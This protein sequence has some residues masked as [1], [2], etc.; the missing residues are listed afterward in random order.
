M[1]R[2]A[3]KRG[4][5]VEGSRQTLSVAKNPTLIPEPPTGPND[6]ID[7]QF[8][9]DFVITSR[10]NSPMV[11]DTPSASIPPPVIRPA[12]QQD[13]EP[14][15][16]FIRP[17]VSAGRLLERTMAELDL[18]IE[19]GFV[20]EADGRIVGFAALEV[21][22]RKLAEIRSLA[23]AEPYR[24]LGVGKQLIAA[25]LSLARERNIMEIMAITSNETFF[26]S[27]GFDFTL[28]GERKALFFQPD[29]P[30]A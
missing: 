17:Y 14:V 19:D 26:Q 13:V 23:V 8:D 22:S 3:T 10:K 9:D 4:R 18:L 16:A 6:R 29:Q 5:L 27:C 7:R 20:A 30:Q 25:C 12:R 24:R 2:Q 28:P 21:Y 11:N 15:H 1:C